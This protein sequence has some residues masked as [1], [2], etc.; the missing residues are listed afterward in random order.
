MSGSLALLQDIWK[1]STSPF[2]ITPGGELNF[3]DIEAA[4]GLDLSAIN[5]GDVVC[6]VGDFDPLSIQ[7]LLQLIERGAVVVPLTK[8]T[9]PQHEYFFEVTN[10]KAIISE[11]TL[12]L[13]D[14][15]KVRDGLLTTFSQRKT[16][17][18]ILFTSGTTGKPKAILHDFTGFLERFRTPRP[19]L[20][21][22]S[23]LL[24][25]HI[26]GLNT[27]FHTLFNKGLIV[28]PQ[29]RDVAS[30]L[31]AC[32]EHEVELLPTTPTFLRMLLMSEYVTDKFPESLRLITYGTERMDQVT[33]S[34][35]CD[36]LPQVEF[37][38]TY[39]MS[40]LGILRIKTRARDSLWMQVGGEGVETKVVD[41]V[42]HIRSQ[43]RMVG[44]VNAPDPFDED[45]WYNTTDIVETD[46]DWLKI[47]GRTKDVANVGGLKFS[48][49]EVE[50]V[51]LEFPGVELAKAEAKENPITGNH[52]ELTVQASESSDLNIDELRQF[53]KTRLE[54]HKQP[55]RVRVG[56]VGVSPR[57]KKT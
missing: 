53:L 49:S 2:L 38:Q 56:T 4:Q 6:L 44:Y 51:A 9:Q 41:D 34:R 55:M 43:N 39:G 52:V 1:A 26:G 57:Y 50:D 13:T 22:L 46:G 7:L 40:E 25:D 10:P 11:G 19:S 45:G 32:A 21:T 27:L 12:V 37:K 24:F 3:Q 16:A 47:T 18:L 29:S 14:G 30:V 20:K 23:F 31:K 33:L 15:G 17:G 5:P 35:L 8:E 54:P 42:L 28:S 36:L 48:T